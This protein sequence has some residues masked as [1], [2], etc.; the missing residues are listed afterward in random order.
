[1]SS[2]LITLG[3]QLIASPGP[4]DE[5]YNGTH[6]K[7]GEHWWE[8]LAE[9]WYMEPKMIGNPQK[10]HTIGPLY[11]T[12]QI[13]KLEI[14]NGYNDFF[15]GVVPTSGR[16]FEWVNNKPKHLNTT[17]HGF[18]YF[19]GYRDW[20]LELTLRSLSEWAKNKKCM[21]FVMEGDYTWLDPK[22]FYRLP[23]QDR[24]YDMNKFWEWIMLEHP[25]LS[26]PNHFY[27][28]CA[29]DRK[30]N[31]LGHKYVFDVISTKISKI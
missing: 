18:H 4:K 26:H 29:P 25:D 19:D 9:H 22:K 31:S 3:D 7:T 15:I 28:H 5:P 1:M 8:L 6:V 21:F 10:N 17:E 24:S 30:L 20:Q 27:Q 23:K 12:S 13:L 11:Y 2:N 14:D 16:S